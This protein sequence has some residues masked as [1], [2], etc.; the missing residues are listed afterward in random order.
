MEK[1]KYRNLIFIVTVIIVAGSSFIFGAY[2]SESNLVT[3]PMP[4][5]NVA[6]AA[7]KENT[8]LELF[9]SV[10]NKLKEK[11]IHYSE[12]NDEDR[13]YGAIQGLTAS[14]GDPYTVFMTPKEA[15]QFNES[16]GGSFDGI[17]AE[18]GLKDEILTVIAP[19]KDGPADKAG[20]KAGDRIIKINDVTTSNMSIEDAVTKIRGKKGTVVKLEIYREGDK[21][22]RVLEVTRDTIV[23][24][25]TKTELIDGV[26]VIH[27]Y[28]FGDQVVK[29]FQKA[30]KE[31]KNSGAKYMV[32]DLRGNPGGYLESAVDIASYFIPKGK[33]I[34]SEDFVTSDEKEVHT[35]YGY[36]D[37]YPIPKVVVLAD[38]G[39]ASASEI[40]AGALRDHKIAKL[41]GTKTFGKGSVQELIPM[42]GGTS[43]KVTIARW[44]IPSGITIDHNGITPDVEV[45]YV[46]NEKDPKFDNQLMKAIEVVKE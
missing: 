43:L 22:T 15:K 31:Y 29:E 19:I 30:L 34:V 21:D 1:N 35:S 39:S 23:I 28:T 36:T 9:F 38:N 11:S 24:P 8:D 2:A 7:S 44:L 13:V 32:L 41:V 45:K 25:T 26:F 46:A 6:V 27:I 42:K 40:L 12:K 20:A 16:I 3:I 18:L 14:L 10:W 33:T 17:G 37:I 4:Q 5:T